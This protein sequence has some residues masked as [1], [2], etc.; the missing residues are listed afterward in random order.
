MQYQVGGSDSV[1]LTRAGSS[2]Q[3]FMVEVWRVVLV[4]FV[5]ALPVRWRSCSVLE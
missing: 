3:F 1:R 5:E 4:E 2:A